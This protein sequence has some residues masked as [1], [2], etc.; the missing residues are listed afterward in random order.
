MTNEKAF[1]RMK[2]MMDLRGFTP[3]TQK[4]TEIARLSRREIIEKLF[5]PNLFAQCRNGFR[6]TRM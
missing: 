6:W 4:L 3:S 1:K 5:G 2:E